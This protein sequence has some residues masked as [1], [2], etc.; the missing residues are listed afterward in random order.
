[1]PEITEHRRRPAHQ[2]ADA[3]EQCRRRA[4]KGGDQIGRR[5][6][7]EHGIRVLYPVVVRT[8]PAREAP[9]E[10]AEPGEEKASEKRLAGL[11]LEMH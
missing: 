2:K 1:M 4:E 10:Y 3:D 11:R 6:N 8:R 7:S 9:S 5:S